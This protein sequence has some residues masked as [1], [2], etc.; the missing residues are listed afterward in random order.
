MF[1]QKLKQIIHN[2]SDQYQSPA[3]KVIW[4]TINHNR[5][6]IA[7]N[8]NANLL[9][10]A[11]EGSTFGLIYL[12][13]NVLQLQN[14][15]NILNNPLIKNTFLYP[16]LQPLDQGQLFISLIVL[17]VF[18]QFLRNGL[19]YSGAIAS[20][21]LGAQIQAQMTE[22]IFR[23]IIS[24]SFPCASGYKVGDLTNYVNQAS[25]TV[26][27]QVKYW[28]SLAIIG[29]TAVAHGLV[30]IGLAPSLSLITTIICLVLII[31]QKKLLPKIR[32]IAQTL[33]KVQADISKQVVENIQALR[34]I[35]TFGSQKRAI[36]EIHKLEIEFVKQLKHQSLLV[37]L[38]QPLGRSITLICIASILI[39]GFI[40]LKNSTAI[41]PT[42][43]TFLAV[44]NRLAT[45]LNGIA[46]MTNRLAEN[47]G[48]FARL[49]E[50]LSTEDKQFTP[51]DGKIFNGLHK[52]IKL[53][54][55]YLQYLN[56]PEP[57]LTNL[58]FK[59]EKGKITALIGG[60]GAGKSS[61]AD[62][63]IGLYQPTKGFIL[64][65]GVD[66]SEYSLESWRKNL[67]VVSQDTFIFN[68]SI[69]DNIRYGLPEAS[70][71]QVIQASMAAYA[72]EFIQDLP[73]GYETVVG[74]RGYRLSG[75][76]RQRLALARAILKQPEILILDEATSALD[77]HSERLVQDALAE[78]QRHR[79]VLVIAHRLST[80]VNADLIIV[81]EKGK[82][83]DS[84]S[85]QELLNKGGQYAQ[86]WE[87]QSH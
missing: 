42:L 14:T 27:N 50:I 77:S 8:I 10:A 78:F 21:Y 54:K 40:F 2:F 45:H 33:A 82:I 76:Q 84:G 37:E 32:I 1:K 79:T 56:T 38:V 3:Y 16:I 51:T 26:M 9:S 19:E 73:E 57:T 24:F 31:I 29:M 72:D 39:F 75:G 44:L 46:N 61:I 60:S 80:I 81:L 4:A 18:M 64:I 6:L 5:L 65:D 11:S 55:V 67:G 53:E 25:I 87:L 13:L 35:H 83:V 7:I 52:E 86:Y 69:L 41:L 47:S 12:A 23:Q 30:L 15:E 22:R 28:N 58:S 48:R 20:D 74:E 85:H 59:L 63:L 66:L 70:K 62:L 36:T 34:V 68:Q 49:E 43:I 71:E 17:A